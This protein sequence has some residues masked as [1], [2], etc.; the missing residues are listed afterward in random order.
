LDGDYVQIFPVLA[1]MQ[2][3]EY[4]HGRDEHVKKM[5]HQ[6][7]TKGLTVKK[8]V[9]SDDPEPANLI[10]VGEGEIRILPTNKFPIHAEISVRGSH[11]FLFS[12][13]TTPMAAIMISHEVADAVRV[14][15]ELAWNGAQSYPS[16]QGH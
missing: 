2:S 7:A 12:Y 15:F 5:R 11:V 13:K 14:L 3:E 1:V 10:D 9:A 4:I 8:L 6:H 16:K